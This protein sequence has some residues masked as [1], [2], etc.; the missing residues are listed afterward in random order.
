MIAFV[1][2]TLFDGAICSF[3]DLLFQVTY[4]VLKKVHALIT[5][6]HF[7]TLENL[8]VT[9]QIYFFEVISSKVIISLNRKIIW[10]LTRDQNF[11][12][13]IISKYIFFI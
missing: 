9:V 5:N 11:S 4:R 13:Y 2:S 7:C 1:T 12:P 3:L 6:L 8:Q 10:V